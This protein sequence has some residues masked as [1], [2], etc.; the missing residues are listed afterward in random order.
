MGRFVYVCRI[1]GV[2]VAVCVCVYMCLCVCVY[3]S[4]GFRGLTGLGIRPVT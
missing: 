1:L 3:V 2:H 4:V